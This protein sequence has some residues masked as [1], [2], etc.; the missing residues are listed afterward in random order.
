MWHK[1]DIA[2][3]AV[4]L[5]ALFGPD[6]SAVR[7]TVVSG[8][9]AT[10]TLI[11]LFTAWGTVSKLAS[12]VIAGGHLVVDSHSKDVQHKEGGTIS[13]V[14]VKDGDRVLPGTLLVTLDDTAARAELEIIAKSKADLQTKIARLEAERDS[15]EEIVFPDEILA[16]SEEPHIF[17][18][19]TNALHMFAARRSLRKSERQQLEQQL[20]QL[21][22]LIKGYE[23]Q[24]KAAEE[25]SKLVEED[26]ARL[27]ELYEEKL[28]PVTRLSAAKRNATRLK[29]QVGAAEAEIARAK[30]RVSE[31]RLAIIQF[32]EEKKSQILSELQDYRTQLGKADERYRA[33][34]DVV[35]RTR[36]RA[37][38]SGYVDAMQVHAGGAVVQPGQI[39]LTVVPA[40][41][42]LL[43]EAKVSAK[44]IDQIHPGQ[45]VRLRFSAFNQKTTPE[46]GGD[47]VH[48][49]ADA[50]Q[51]PQTGF[52]YYAVR[53]RFGAEHLLEDETV[54]LVPGMP[55]EIFITTGERTMLSYLLKPFS[56]Q[57]AR[58]FRES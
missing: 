56:D 47:I 5:R 48:I 53:V 15:T 39:I 46:F 36:I 58:A 57:M 38:Q 7:A 1:A 44:D 12:A 18:A 35:E 54:K 32:N 45:N 10:L 9:A 26:V 28:V 13:D 34:Q 50:A 31:V 30:E 37:P 4:R 6:N 49:S 51:D 25:E 17:A 40:E 55:A 2:A 24:K 3:F 23:V 52:M 43:V 21:E 22:E 42:E 19:M 14:H 33:A 16:Q 11:V 8:Y 41:D 29:G 27:E 20:V